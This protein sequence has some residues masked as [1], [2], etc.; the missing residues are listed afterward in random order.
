M[1]GNNEEPQFTSESVSVSG[2]YQ[3][4]PHLNREHWKTVKLS[5]DEWLSLERE[6]DKPLSDALRRKTCETIS[7]FIH[8]L[9]LKEKMPTPRQYSTQLRTQIVEIIDTADNLLNQITPLGGEPAATLGISKKEARRLLGG[10]DATWNIAAKAAQTTKDGDELWAVE[11]HVRYLIA[12][13]FPTEFSTTH[14]AL[15]GLLRALHVLKNIMPS[16]NEAGPEGNPELNLLLVDLL[17]IAQDAGD[18]L[19]LAPHDIRDKDMRGTVKPRPAYKFAVRTTAMVLESAE[20]LVAELGLSI[21]DQSTLLG[22]I[23]ECLDRKPGTL[24][25]PLE[26]AR[27]I[28]EGGRRE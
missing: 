1:P 22:R 16:R 23:R 27:T 26:A 25:D 18:N 24:I 7:Q 15:L 2:V 3:L 20:A 28:V 19:D 5:D 17:R 8:A 21:D 9:R 10:R 12:T 11:D 14:G 6:L 13:T 4:I